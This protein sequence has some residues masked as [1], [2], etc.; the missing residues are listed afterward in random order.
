[1]P[2][3]DLCARAPRAP[4]AAS[5]VQHSP[6][7]PAARVRATSGLP[8]AARSPQSSSGESVS[9]LRAPHTLAAEAQ[10]VLRLRPPV[11]PALLRGDGVPVLRAARAAAFREI[12]RR[13]LPQRAAPHLLLLAPLPREVRLLLVLARRSLP[14]LIPPI[15]RRSLR[16]ESPAAN[17]PPRL[18]SIPPAALS[19]LL[20]LVLPVTPLLSFSNQPCEIVPMRPCTTSR[21]PQCARFFRKSSRVPRRPSRRA[22]ADTARTVSPVG[23]RRSSPSGY[24]LEFDAS[25]PRPRIVTAPRPASYSSRPP[26]GISSPLSMKWARP[27]IARSYQSLWRINRFYAFVK[28]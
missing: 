16:R 26:A 11:R 14:R 23:P 10:L 19:A 7:A 12:L 9:V 6:A 5:V 17:P 27:P 3:P 28:N 18:R 25:L 15:P 4:K 13:G 1:M 20:P 22:S 24:E 2:V 21:L 8:K